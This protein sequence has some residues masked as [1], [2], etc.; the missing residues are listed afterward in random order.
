MLL[1]LTNN[2]IKAKLSAHDKC[3]QHTNM[4]CNAEMEVGEFT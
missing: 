4:K 3:Y 1:S 2:D